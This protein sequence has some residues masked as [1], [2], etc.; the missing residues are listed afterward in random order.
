MDFRYGR[1]SIREIV[2]QELK[3]HA[4]R[5][6]LLPVVH[7]NGRSCRMT[8]VDSLKHDTSKRVELFE[9]FQEW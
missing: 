8:I 7:P 3:K 6:G 5:L 9:D 1:P 2:H 4:I